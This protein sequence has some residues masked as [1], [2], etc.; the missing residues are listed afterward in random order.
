MRLQRGRGRR[1]KGGIRCSRHINRSV[2]RQRQRRSTFAATGAEIRGIKELRTGRVKRRQ[3]R[4]AAVHD[5][6]ASGERTDEGS[7]TCG[8]S[9]AGLVSVAGNREVR[10][11]S[12]AG[13]PQI[14]LP[15][16]S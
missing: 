12:P 15:V 1:K 14:S 5:I 7:K 2:R 16:D 6:S 13:E 4:I 8:G 11:V 3:V 9:I 10:V